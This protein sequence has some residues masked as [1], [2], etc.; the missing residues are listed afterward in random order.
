MV[1]A[2]LNPAAVINPPAHI[3]LP[4]PTPPVTCRAPVAVDVALVILVTVVTPLILT[5]PD[6]SNFAVG[7]VDPRPKLPLMY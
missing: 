6:T 5:P 1:P 4:T 3:S 7:D 2:D